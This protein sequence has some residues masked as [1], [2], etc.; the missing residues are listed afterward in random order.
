[1]KKTEVL[2]PAG[3]SIEPPLG[4]KLTIDE[5]RNRLWKEMTE[6]RALVRQKKLEEAFKL[7]ERILDGNPDAE[8]IEALMCPVDADARELAPDLMYDLLASLKLKPLPRS[9]KPWHSLMRVNLLERLTRSEEAFLATEELTRLPARYGWMRILRGIMLTRIRFAYKEAETEFRAVLKTTPRFWKTKAYIAEAALCQ[10]ERQR[11]LKTMDELVSGLKGYERAASLGWKGELRLWCGDYV[12]ALRELTESIRNNAHMSMCWRAAS[13]YKLGKP[14]QALTELDAYLKRW[15][16]D[17]EGLIW[18][19]EIKR[20]QGKLKEALT[21]LDA[22][23]RLRNAP[24]WAHLNR[25][26]LHAANRDFDAMWSDYYV[27]PA[28]V[29][30]FFQWKCK[31]SIETDRSPEKV[32]KLLEAVLEAG[33]GLRR[34]DC[35]LYPVW[36][37]RP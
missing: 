37:E 5:N 6:V 30:S 19:G 12:G 18:R 4:G 15:D 13:L 31:L 9:L 36:M 24:L 10:G 32:C 7:C 17:Q 16:C 29:V 35:Y 21:D 25:A 23:V 11:A 33:K 20:K 34:N 8:I 27:L 14:D 26:L 22:A 28:Q 2:P 1:M 3:P